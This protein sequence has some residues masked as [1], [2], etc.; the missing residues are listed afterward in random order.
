M[1]ITVNV[2]EKINSVNVGTI[3]TSL[4]E[5][6][7]STYIVTPTTTGGPAIEGGPSAMDPIV[8][9]TCEICRVR[10]REIEREYIDREHKS[11]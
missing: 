10:E 8:Q 1:N 7:L 6:M 3:L 4:R 11:L 9:H 2:V 5:L